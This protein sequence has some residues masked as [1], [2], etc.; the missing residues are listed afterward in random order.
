MR[1]R[2]FIQSAGSSIVG[3]A[4][5]HAESS[6]RVVADSSLNQERKSPRAITMWEFSWIERRWDGAG[7]EDWDRA[8]D[9]LVDRGYNAVRI[10]PFPHLLATDPN[11]TWTLLPR[12]NTQDWGSPDRNEIQLM[13]ALTTFIGKCHARG[14]KIGL[15]TWYRQDVDNTRMEIATPEIMA[16]QWNQ[17]LGIIREAGLIDAILYVDLCNE[18]PGIDWAPFV[19]P[20][21]TYGD[22]QKPAS[23]EWMHTALS[24]VHEQFPQLPLLFSVASSPADWTKTDLAG[25]D[26][27]E[28]H[29]WMSQQN[30]EEFYKLTGYNYE[31]FD[32]KGYTNLI[33]NAE[34]TYRARPGYWQSLLT[35]GIDAL[36]EGSR[37]V[38]LPL[39]TTECWA[40]VDYKDWPLLKW[41]WVKELCAVGTRHAASTGR[42]LAIGTSN[43][44]GPQF[45]GMWRDVNWHRQLTN[46][47]RNSEINRELRSGKLYSRL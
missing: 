18:W 4:L 47:I 8:L 21:M 16:Q 24:I 31:P 40:V 46:V 15:S 25:F 36:A 30:N 27:M 3:A 1:R 19:T 14:I 32:P 6:V 5:L 33:L 28:Q 7:Y 13:P 35:A 29:I 42:W 34:K 45:V 10:D 26:A 43:F 11:R 12:W 39:M 17:T 37:K 38:A 44:C 23:L 22:W 41:D 9:E 20:K 2:D